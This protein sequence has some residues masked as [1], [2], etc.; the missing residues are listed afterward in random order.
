M[1]CYECKK[2]VISKEKMRETLEKW[3]Y[4]EHIS[5]K[6]ETPRWLP[7]GSRVLN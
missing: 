4:F 1:C 3:D 7:H 2:Y 6:W 5:Q